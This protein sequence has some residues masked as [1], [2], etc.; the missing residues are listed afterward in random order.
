[1]IIRTVG[2]AGVADYAE[3]V[4]RQSRRLK[5]GSC[6]SPAKFEIGDRDDGHADNGN[7]AS[8]AKRFLLEQ[9][10]PRSTYGSHPQ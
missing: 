8:S 3:L 10:G 2:E 5:C 7:P 9:G 1:M 6:G 4:G